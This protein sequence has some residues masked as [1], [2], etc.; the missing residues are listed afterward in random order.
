M[1]S[2]VGPWSAGETRFTPILFTQTSELFHARPVF[3]FLVICSSACQIARQA[4]G[5]NRGA[6]RLV[7][8]SLKEYSETLNQRGRLSKNVLKPARN[9]RRT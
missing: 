7:P 9:S 3:Q 6:E 5:C 1:E 8:D 4:R 2:S